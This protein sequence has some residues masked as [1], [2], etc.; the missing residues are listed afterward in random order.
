MYARKVL[1]LQEIAPEVPRPLR[2]AEY[3]QLAV[4]GA[5]DDERVELLHGVIV[6]MSPHGPAHDAVIDRLNEM[7]VRAVGLRGKVRV[8]SSFNAVGDSEPEPDLAIVPRAEYDDAHPDRAFLIVEV[9]GS[10]LRKDRGFKARLYAESGVHEYWVVNLVD[11]VIEVSSDPAQGVYRSSRI[12]GKG[13]H[14][15]LS[16]FADIEV[17]VDD[18]LR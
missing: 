10:S 15:A 16:G 17:R 11:R 18:V 14:V 8:Q 4:S 3:D 9:A 1:D 2:R 7:L 6:R 12:F 13:E 5:F